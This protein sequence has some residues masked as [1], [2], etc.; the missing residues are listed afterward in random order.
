MNWLPWMRLRIAWPSMAQKNIL[1]L[2]ALVNMTFAG[3]AQ[4]APLRDKFPAGTPATQT[5]HFQFAIYYLPEPSKEAVSVAQGVIRSQKLRFTMV[6]A[7]TDAPKQPEIALR[8]ENDVTARYAPPDMNSLRY[9]G[10]GLSLEQAQALQNSKN[11]LIFDFG[12][13]RDYVWSALQTATM[14]VEQVARKTSGLIWDEE[15]REVFTPDEWHKRRV[16][17]WSHTPPYLANHTTIHAYQSGEYVRAIT[18]GMSKFGLPDVVAENFSWSL[19]N[20][21]GNLINAFCQAMAE[22]AAFE[23]SGVYELDINAIRNPAMHKQQNSQLMDNAQK[24]AHMTLW[25]GSWEE[26]DPNNRL[27]EIGFD[28]YPGK[29]VHARQTAMLTSL[30]GWQDEIKRIKH[31]EDLIAA[32]R[33]A[34]TKLPALRA[35]FVAGLQPG[36]FIEVKAPFATPTGGQEWMWVEIVSWKGTQISGILKNEPFDIPG[37]HGGE[38]VKVSEGDIFDYIRRYADG[39]V[40]GNETGKII[41]KMQGNSERSN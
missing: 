34:R 10:R 12:Y 29:D 7:T 39:K 28:K 24:V 30:Y 35:A 37:L 38:S 19:N 25:I 16:A 4:A 41:E 26:G 18:L 13:G 40:E 11:A 32:S 5:I 2:L 1:C 21:M 9:F 33:R 23:K 36:E 31:N 20:S 22:G 15:T 14:I 3:V 27:V 17:S 8:L 6:D